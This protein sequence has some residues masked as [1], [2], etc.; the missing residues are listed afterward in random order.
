MTHS[1]AHARNPVPAG[2]VLRWQ[3]FGPF[4]SKPELAVRIAL[5][6]ASVAHEPHRTN[7]RCGLAVLLA[8]VGRDAEA[9][10]QWREAVQTSAQDSAIRYGLAKALLNCRRPLEAIAVLEGLRSEI[11]GVV[12]DF[13]LTYGRALAQTGKHAQALAIYLG[14]LESDPTSNDSLYRATRLLTQA[15]SA[16]DALSLIESLLA[17]GVCTTRML[18]EKVTVLRLLERHTEAAALEGIEQFFQTGALP[19]PEGWQ[20]REALNA[21]L[22]TEL[23]AHP[24]R[25][26]ENPQRRTRGGWRIDALNI[27]A[28][29]AL[30]SLF[31][32]VRACIDAYVAR[33]QDAAPHPFLDSMPESV[34]LTTWAIWLR[35]DAYQEWHVHPDGWLS[36]VYYVSVPEG[37]VGTQGALALGTPELSDVAT[38]IP[39][40][41]MWHMPSSGELAL[42]PSHCYHRTIPGKVPADRL[43]VAFDVID[44]GRRR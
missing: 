23:N 19:V 42:F 1:S 29:P 25:R 33:L 7:L 24:G 37:G 32:A 8:E 43:S 17:R 2:S 26:F 9:L 11:S 28:H 12:T 30:R 18:V 40:Y 36:G 16:G 4:A 13:D 22:I 38:T 27:P 6:Q 20:D 3:P 34:R 14:R 15:G 44:C 21:A 41:C 35:G 10:E 5:L 31:I 39:G